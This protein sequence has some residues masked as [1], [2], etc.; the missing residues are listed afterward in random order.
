MHSH[1]KINIGYYHWLEKQI[2]PAMHR[3]R[4]KRKPLTLVVNDVKGVKK[5]G[6]VHIEKTLIPLESA[7]SAVPSPQPLSSSEQIEHDCTE[8]SNIQTDF[9]GTAANSCYVC[10][11]YSYIH[12][13]KV[14][15]VYCKK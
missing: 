10:M 4:R 1:Y 15:K 13:P 3:I 14:D 12:T 5:S 9:I 2:N 7:T 11:S 8:N 6:K